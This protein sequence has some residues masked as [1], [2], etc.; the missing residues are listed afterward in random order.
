[1]YKRSSVQHGWPVYFCS[2]IFTTSWSGPHRHDTGAQHNSPNTQLC[3][4]RTNEGAK[5]V[6]AIL[7]PQLTVTCNILETRSMKRTKNDRQNCIIIHKITASVMRSRG[8]NWYVCI[9][10]MTTVTCGDGFPSISTPVFLNKRAR[11]HKN[12]PLLCCWG[13]FSE[14]FQTIWSLVRQDV[15]NFLQRL[16]WWKGSHMVP[17]GLS[18]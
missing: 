5:A 9:R 6:S 11:I 7:R 8:N 16:N 13:L 10:K 18:I 2:T 12:R 14:W 15:K 4:T 3:K 1:M 17:S